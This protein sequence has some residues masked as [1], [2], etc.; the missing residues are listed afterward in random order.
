MTEKSRIQFRRDSK[1]N[2]EI[3]N[4]QK[5]LPLFINPFFFCNCL[6]FGAVAVPAGIVGDFCITTVV[7]SV[8]VC[9]QSGCPAIHNVLNGFSLNKV[10]RMAFHIGSDVGGKDILNFNAHC[11]QCGQRD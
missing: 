11:Y 2:M 8:Y 7:T 3:G 5:M 9:A 1:N 6:A 10:Q 4:V